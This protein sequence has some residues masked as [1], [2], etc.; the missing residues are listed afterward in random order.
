MA[1]KVILVSTWVSMSRIRVQIALAEKGVEYEFR[2][3][4]LTN[5]SQLLLQMNPVHKRTPV[6]IHSENRSLMLEK[7]TDRKRRG[8]KS[9]QRG[10]HRLPQG[11]DRLPQGVGNEHLETSHTLGT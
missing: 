10:V 11:V 1:D 4:N 7:S 3:E 6:L 2:G 9:S 8:P 5:K